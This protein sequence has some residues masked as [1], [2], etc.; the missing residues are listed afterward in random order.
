MSGRVR[1]CVIICN[2]GET[3][4]KEREALHG[5][6]VRTLVSAG[7]QRE[8]LPYGVFFSLFDSLQG[9]RLFFLL[10]NTKLF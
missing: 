7:L 2:Q 8:A 1:V 9:Q 3:G 6:F 4:R 10:C 5:P